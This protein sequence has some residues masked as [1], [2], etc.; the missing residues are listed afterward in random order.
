MI[1]NV[2]AI[3]TQFNQLQVDYLLIGGMS[4]LLRH[5][6]VLTFDVDLWIEPGAENR[7]LA[8]KAL[9]LLN[10]S[11]GRSEDDWEPVSVKPTGWLTG[12]SVFCLQC[13]HG[14]IDIFLAVAGLEDWQTVN[15]RGISDTTSTVCP[16]RSISDQDLL[17]CQLVLS[18]TEQKKDRVAYLRSRLQP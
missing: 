9:A 7:Q 5:Q 10:A 14:A 4:Y 6:P 17:Q 3:L 11:W 18:E 15:Q 12:Q 2:D 16:Y 1:V 8:E 13:P